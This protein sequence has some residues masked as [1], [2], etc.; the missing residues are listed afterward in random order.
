MFQSTDA[1]KVFGFKPTPGM[2]VRVTIANGGGQDIR[3]V[4]TYL[5]ADGAVEPEETIHLTPQEEAE[6]PYP[7][8]KDAGEGADA[9]VLEFSDDN[10]SQCGV[11]LVFGE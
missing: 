6:L 5:G 7:L 10:G 2:L 3:A 9:W 8:Q 11:A 4:P 1:C